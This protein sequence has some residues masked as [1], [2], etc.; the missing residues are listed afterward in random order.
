MALHS[1]YEQIIKNYLWND[2]GNNKYF[3]AINAKGEPFMTESLF[4]ALILE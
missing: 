2:I 3:D 1:L 4:I